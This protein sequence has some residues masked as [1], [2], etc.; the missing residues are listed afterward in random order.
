MGTIVYNENTY[1]P[2]YPSIKNAYFTGDIIRLGREIGRYD[3]YFNKHPIYV[4]ENT[5]ETILIGVRYYGK[6]IGVQ[7]N[8]YDV[9]VKEGCDV[10]NAEEFLLN[11]FTIRFY[12]EEK[13]TDEFPIVLEKNVRLKDMLGEEILY[14]DIK[15]NI[16]ANFKWGAQIIGLPGFRCYKNIDVLEDNSL[17]TSVEIGM[18]KKYYKINEEYANIF[19]E[20]INNHL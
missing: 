19:L 12:D 7:Y 3:I 1:Y 8:E 13:N 15:S 11:E 20:V 9:W 4:L 17:Y 6:A 10:F 18:D 14:E 2:C 5:N 16:I